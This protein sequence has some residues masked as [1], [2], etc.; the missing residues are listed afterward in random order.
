MAGD[1]SQISRESLL[2]EQQETG[3]AFGNLTT[4][5]FIFSHPPI[6]VFSKHRLSAYYEAGIVLGAGIRE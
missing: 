4:L 1:A 6:H 5:P 2:Q 3:P